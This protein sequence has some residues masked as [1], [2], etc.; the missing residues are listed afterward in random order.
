[1]RNTVIKIVKKL[2][3]LTA[4][5]VVIL[6]SFSFTSIQWEKNK[7]SRIKIHN[8]ISNLFISET[9]SIEKFNNNDFIVIKENENTIGYLLVTQAL[10]K[11]TLFDYY[12]IYDKHAEILKVEVLT[13][14]ENHGYEICNNRWLKQFIGINSASEFQYNNQVNAISGATISVNSI[15]SSIYY[16][17]QDLKIIIK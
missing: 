6:L 8:S 9:Y 2:S 16:N 14:R 13:Y 5:V 12:I 10:S 17:T 15:K 11:N 4:L 3:K 7:K 1:M